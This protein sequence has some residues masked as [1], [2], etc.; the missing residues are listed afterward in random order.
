MILNHTSTEQ[1]VNDFCRVYLVLSK[2]FNSKDTE[3]Y[4]HF[5]NDFYVKS[6]YGGF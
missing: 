4:I 1:L 2:D 6:P 3:Q 5:E